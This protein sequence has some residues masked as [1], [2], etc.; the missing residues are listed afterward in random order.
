MKWWI[1]LASS[2]IKKVNNLGVGKELLEAMKGRRGE[3]GG[4][5]QR[6]IKNRDREDW[7]Q[8]NAILGRQIF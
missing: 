8:H 3:D 1:V 5:R 7:K 4:E 6:G 2:F